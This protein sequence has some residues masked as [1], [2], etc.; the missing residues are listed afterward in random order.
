MVA[1]AVLGP[2]ASASAQTL[3]TAVVSWAEAPV[4]AWHSVGTEI[5]TVLVLDQQVTLSGWRSYDAKWVEVY[6][7]SGLRGWVEAHRL[8]SDFQFIN[9]AVYAAAYAPE[10]LDSF[11]NDP[12][13]ATVRGARLNFRAGAGEAFPTLKTLSPGQWVIMD[14]RTPD[15]YWVN[16]HLPSG[17]GGWVFGRYLDGKV[18]I[19]Y[20]PILSDPSPGIFEV[21]TAPAAPVGGA[22]SQP[23]AVNVGQGGYTPPGTGGPNTY[24]VRT[25]D[26]LYGIAAYYGVN[27]AALAAYNNITNPNYIT[28]GQVIYIP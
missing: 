4:Y 18:P 14:G 2:V 15:G 10:T 3:P 27:A 7:D 28:I 19:T 26:S 12:F 1:L 16:V 20:L 9:L 8:R 11:R 24:T 25:G 13:A 22:P 21:S 6:L 5:L 17:E 23:T